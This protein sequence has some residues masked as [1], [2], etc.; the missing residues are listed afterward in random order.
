MGIV[1]RPGHVGVAIP[2]VG[3]TF[4]PSNTVSYKMVAFLYYEIIAIA[5]V[6]NC[7]I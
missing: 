7:E 6:V 3:V 1:M 2:R 5:L 4:I